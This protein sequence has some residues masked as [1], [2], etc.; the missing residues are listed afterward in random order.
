MLNLVLNQ[1]VVRFC[2]VWFSFGKSSHTKPHYSYTNT[3][4]TSLG[5]QRNS[6]FYKGQ[7]LFWWIKNDNQNWKNHGWF[8][9]SFL[10]KNV[11][12]RNYKT[13]E[14][15]EFMLAQ[16]QFLHRKFSEPTSFGWISETL[17]ITAELYEKRI[18]QSLVFNEENLEVQRFE[19]NNRIAKRS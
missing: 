6:S 5:I 13:C 19:L 17:N 8:N 18:Y 3:L 16:N 14:K 9:H 12:G 7:F 10:L 1:S 2:Y 15:S 11:T 4:P